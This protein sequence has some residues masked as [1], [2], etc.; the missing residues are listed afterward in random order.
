MFL[1]EATEKVI[2]DT[3]PYN[4]NLYKTQEEVAAERGLVCKYPKPNEL[5]V[6]IDSEE[7]L[8]EFQR[9]LHAFKIHDH[10][11]L[12]AHDTYTQS[13]SGAPHYHCVITFPESETFTE[14]ERIAYQAALND[15]PLKVFLSVLR[16]SRGVSNPTTFFEKP[17]QE[18]KPEQQQ[19]DKY[20][21]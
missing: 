3:D 17:E 16:V 12:Y 1:P 7:Q 18:T 10:K 5:F 6:D 8:N 9:R 20:P 11:F 14:L 2:N 4:P 15:D 19:E 21:W 13:N